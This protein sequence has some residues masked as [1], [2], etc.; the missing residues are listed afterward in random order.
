[1]SNCVPRLRGAALFRI[2]YSNRQYYLTEPDRYQLQK[3]LRLLT[4]LRRIAETGTLSRGV[5]TAYFRYRAIINFCL[6]STSNIVILCSIFV[7]YSRHGGICH[8]RG[9]IGPLSLMFW[10]INL[11]P[12]GD[13]A[14]GHEG[15]YSTTDFLSDQ[16]RRSTIASARLSLISRNVMTSDVARRFTAQTVNYFAGE[17]RFF[18]QT[19]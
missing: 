16:K 19:D 10:T 14:A 15:R 13:P 4:L 2:P 11:A 1:M 12:L 18:R 9:H 5:Q 7:G 6:D 3:R 17:P 8:F